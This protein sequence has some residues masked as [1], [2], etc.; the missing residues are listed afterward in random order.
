[1]IMPGFRPI[2]PDKEAAGLIAERNKRAG[3]A[4]WPVLVEE[5]RRVPGDGGGDDLICVH[6]R[7]T[8]ERFSPVRID[9][10]DKLHEV[11]AANWPAKQ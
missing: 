10:A 7:V 2:D 5:I 9:L 8:V 6:L 4:S 1:M 3:I 11:I